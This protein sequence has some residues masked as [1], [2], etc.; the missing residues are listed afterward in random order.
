MSIIHRG[1]DYLPQSEFSI[2]NTLQ[3]NLLWLV[4]ESDNLIC[5]RFLFPD[6][7]VGYL[8]NIH[9]EYLDNIHVEYLDNIHVEY[10]DNIHVGY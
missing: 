10:L 1:L 4:L 6:Q 7:H 5:I 9:V 8:D 3:G 2:S